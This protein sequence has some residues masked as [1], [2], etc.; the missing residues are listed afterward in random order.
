MLELK[1]A[2]VH[3][4]N[5]FELVSDNGETVHVGDV[6][7]F[8]VWTGYSRIVVS[9]VVKFGKYGIQGGV[10]GNVYA[11]GYYIKQDYKDPATGKNEFNE[12][13][14]L[15]NEIMAGRVVKDNRV[16]ESDLYED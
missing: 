14:I 3:G 6:I 13:G 10:W 15:D 11:L 9:G 2:S 1:E 5:V 16:Q 4:Q 7:E 8:Q 12:W